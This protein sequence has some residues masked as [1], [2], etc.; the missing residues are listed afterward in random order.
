MALYKAVLNGHDERLTRQRKKKLKRWLDIHERF[1]ES[2]KS[3]SKLD[4][5]FSFQI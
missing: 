3:N 4:A 2:A 1:H 5:G